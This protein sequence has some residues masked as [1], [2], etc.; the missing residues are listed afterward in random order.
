MPIG[1][2]K[3]EDE[4]FVR[5]EYEKKKAA[6]AAKF[7]LLAEE[8]KNKQ[9]EL[10]WMYCPKCGTT[11]SEIDFKGIKI[12]KCSHCDGVWLDAGELESINKL[13]QGVLGRFL[14]AF[15]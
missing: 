11:L 15:A 3:N 14:K 2:S 6:E 9:K 10:H 13:E 4:Y 8:E 1:P 7:A 12:D 5:Q